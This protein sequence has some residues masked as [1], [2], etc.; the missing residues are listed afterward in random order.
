MRSEAN[1]TKQDHVMLD[2]MIQLDDAVLRSQCAQPD[3]GRASPHVP[4]DPPE[5]EDMPHVMGW[6]NAFA[7]LMLAVG[8]GLIFVLAAT[9][10]LNFG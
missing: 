2:N 1:L 8:L 6:G 10:G 7:Y 5:F 9:G 4:N 3:I